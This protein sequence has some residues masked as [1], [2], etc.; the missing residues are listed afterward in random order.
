MTGTDEAVET[1]KQ[2]M[3]DQRP[4]NATQGRNLQRIVKNDF[5][6]LKAELELFR[7]EERT[8]REQEIRE[9]YRTSRESRTTLEN[10]IRVLNRQYRA[11][12][13][14]LRGRAREM[15]L[16]VNQG[17]TAPSEVVVFGE[18]RLNQDIQAMYREVNGDVNTALRTAEA[19]FYEAERLVLMAT[20]TTQAEKIL[21]G[22]PTSQQLMAE[23]YE[24]R[25]K[26]KEL[27]GGTQ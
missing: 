2:A 16:T 7:V 17:L 6:R 3:E 26:R 15:G 11:E 1:A 4:L 10:E 23:A 19:K 21:S 13:E 8:R 25:A 12:A 20:I 27:T 5:E 18:E 9:N 14:R 22:I 24:Q